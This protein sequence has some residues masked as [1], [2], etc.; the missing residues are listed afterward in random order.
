MSQEENEAVEV[1]AVV[2]RQ[3]GDQICA[4]R[5]DFVDLASSLAGFGE[6]EE[7]ALEE[8]VKAEERLKQ[9]GR[10][11]AEDQERLK[12]TFE[13]LKRTALEGPQPAASVAEAD[14][15]SALLDRLNEICER[16]KWP[17][18][19]LVA[20]FIPNTEEGAESPIRLVSHFALVCGTKA[21]RIHSALCDARIGHIHA[22]NMVAFREVGMTS[23]DEIKAQDDAD[24]EE[25][26]QP[27]LF[28][29]GVSQG[30][31]DAED[32]A[33]K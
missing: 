30:A 25:A 8:L 23:H 22:A 19:T 2:Y 3:E 21:A 18:A 9:Q 32:E 31:A 15:V 16:N 5:E 11:A 27:I 7:E 1:K 17:M 33:L 4:T 14:E 26:V 13:N 20:S 12:A 6:T 29:E 28:E 24:R 10:Q